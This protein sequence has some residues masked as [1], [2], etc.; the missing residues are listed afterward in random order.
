[1]SDN[2]QRIHLV[3]GN[4]SCDLDSTVSPMAL[5]FLFSKNSLMGVPKDALVLPVFNIPYEN[6]PTKTENNF[7]LNKFNIKTEWLVFR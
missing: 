4:E 5:A 3:L 1:M 7:L 2:Y 6:F